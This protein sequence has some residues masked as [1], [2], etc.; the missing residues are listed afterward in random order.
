MEFLLDCNISEETLR[1]ILINNS[2]QTILEAEWNMER[3]VD[4]ISYLRELGITSIDKILINRFDIILRGKDSLKETF[5]SV[6]T[7][8]LIEMINSDIKYVYYLDKY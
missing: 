6:D 7:K 8:K 4:A 2:E 3:V 5:E 1:K